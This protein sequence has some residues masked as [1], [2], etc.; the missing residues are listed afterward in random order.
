MF[1]ESECLPPIEQLDHEGL[2]VDLDPQLNA[3][4]SD[5]VVGMLDDISAGF[6][7]RKLDVIEEVRIDAC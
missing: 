7:N 1:I 3:L 4:A 2:V 5:P 6:V